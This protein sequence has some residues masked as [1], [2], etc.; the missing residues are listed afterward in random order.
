MHPFERL[1]A[2]LSCEQVVAMQE[3]VKQVK[4]DPAVGD[5]IVLLVHYTRGDPRLR[6]GI[7]PR[8]SL[9]LY[10]TAQASAL[11]SGRQ[12]VTPDDVRGLAKAVLA[13]RMVLDTKSRYGGIRNEDIIQESLD[14]T[15]VPR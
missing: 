13:H 3:Q 5:Y 4:V 1:T 8:G 15:P 11:M 7:S 14:K 10:R 12:F 6:L 9:A 2:L